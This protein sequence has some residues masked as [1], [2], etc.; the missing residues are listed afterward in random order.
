MRIFLASLWTTVILVGLALPAS[1]FGTLDIQGIDKIIHLI[2]F[3][4]FGFLWMAALRSALARRTVTVFLAGLLFAVA[5]EFVQEVLPFGRQSDPMDV[6]A[7]MIGLTIGI[8]S[9]RAVR[10]RLRPMQTS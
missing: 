5:T 9:Y 2:L 7:D 4:F 1:G 10:L 8:G 3:F 6:L